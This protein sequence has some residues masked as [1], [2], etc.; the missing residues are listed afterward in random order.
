MLHPGL[1]VGA[2]AVSVG[3]TTDVTVGVNWVVGSLGSTPRFTR[4][5]RSFSNTK[6]VGTTLT[7]ILTIRNRRVYNGCTNQTEIKPLYLTLAN[8]GTKSAVF[9]I[10]GNGTVAGTPNFQPIGNNLISMSDVAGTTVTGGR[11]L[12]SY[13][14]AKGQSINVDLSA[15]NIVI[16]PTLEF[17]ISG[18]MASGSAA[19]LTAT[20][21]WIEDL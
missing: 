20:F 8:D 7:N 12:P 2:Y 3:A 9:E 14:V 18:K 10:R 5:P 4:N 17:V 15:L 13:T 21:T 11:I 6:S 16:P 19:D 1:H